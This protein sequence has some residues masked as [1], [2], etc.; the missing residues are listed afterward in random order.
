MADSQSTTGSRVAEMFATDGAIHVAQDSDG[1][2]WAAGSEGS[3]GGSTVRVEAIS[4]A[5]DAVA[6]G[7]IPG[8]LVAVHLF[9][10]KPPYTIVKP[11]TWRPGWTQWHQDDIP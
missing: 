2:W 4:I 1:M 7:S 8:R 11:P 5:L 10:N 6:T 9:A 3:Y